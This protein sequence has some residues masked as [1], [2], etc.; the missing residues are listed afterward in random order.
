ME[1]VEYVNSPMC[2]WRPVGSFSWKWKDYTILSIA[3]K[4]Y[5]LMDQE[6]RTIGIFES[7]PEA[8]DR[9]WD[10]EQMYVDDVYDEGRM[11]Q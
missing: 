9:A 11:E 4:D 3:E 10:I 5:V 8:A 7:L 1:R 6:N 2:V